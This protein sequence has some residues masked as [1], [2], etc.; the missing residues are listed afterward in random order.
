MSSN[1]KDTDWKRFINFI[2]LDDTAAEDNKNSPELYY[3]H[4]KSKF[5]VLRNK[6]QTLETFFIFI[7]FSSYFIYAAFI[8]FFQT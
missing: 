2:S 4:R 5:L 7:N 3:K 8:D 6:R 1:C